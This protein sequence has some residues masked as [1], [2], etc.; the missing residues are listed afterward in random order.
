MWK[1]AALPSPTNP[2][3]PV[4]AP[5]PAPAMDD[6]DLFNLVE[7]EARKN[8]VSTDLILR[9]IRQESK[10]NPHA[11]SVKGAQGL[12]QLMP[13]TALSYGVTDPFDPVQNVKA[14]ISHM[15]KLLKRYKGDQRQALLDYNGGPAAVQAFQ[16]GH[17]F[18]ESQGYLAAI[19]GQQGQPQQAP[20]TGA[21]P[22][23][24]AP[25][26]FENF[27]QLSAADQPVSYTHLT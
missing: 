6:F 22:P 15:G 3:P 12:M 18:K 8:G 9:Q 23:T 25:D 20:Q 16:S 7:P 21:P 1:D 10:G 17:P 11:V 14:G 5:P 13:A 24:P 27:N 26:D 19:E 4:G 2:D